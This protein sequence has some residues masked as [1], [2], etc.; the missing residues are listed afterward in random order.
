MKPASLNPF[1]IKQLLAAACITSIAYAAPVTKYSSGTDLSLPGSW[2]GGV[3]P[4]PTSGDVATWDSSSLGAGLLVN[5][6]VNWGSINITG[7]AENIGISG[8]G[9]ITTGNITLAGDKTL[10]ISNA[11]ALS[12]NSIYNISNVTGN[13]NTDATISGVISGASRSITKE[14][15]GTLTFTKVNT[16]TGGTFVNA[17]TLIQDLSVGG[18][19]NTLGAVTINAGAVYELL[20]GS[21]TGA[22]TT[23]LQNNTFSGEGTIRKTGTGYIGLAHS[24]SSLNTFNGIFDVQAGTIGVNNGTQGSGRATVQLNGAT[25]KL[26][27][28]TG[29]F[30]IDALT[31]VVGSQVYVSHTA[32]GTLSVGNNNGSGTFAGTIDNIGSALTF[33]KNGSGTQTLTGA[34]TYTGRTTINGGTLELNYES[35]IS[36]LSSSSPLT[37]GGGALSLSGGAT[38]T[39]TLNGLTT[40]ANTGS[41]ILLNANK[42]LTLGALTLAGANSALNFNTAAGG[43]NATTSTLGTSMVVLS[44]QTAG[45]VINKGFTVTDSTGFGLATVD[46]SNNVVRLTSTTLLPASGASSPNNYQIDNNAGGAAAA[47]SSS[48][49]ITASQSAGSITVD[50]TAASGGLTL[51]SG[52]VLSNNTWNFGG[53]GSNTYQIS[54]NAGGAGLKAVASN[55]TITFNNYNAG[56]VTISSPILAN[57]VN[58]VTLNGTGTTTLSGANTFTGAT[59]VNGGTLNLTGSLTSAVTVNTGATLAMSGTAI[60]NG[61]VTVNNGGV[62]N[63][64]TTTRSTDNG[65]NIGTINVASGGTLNISNTKTVAFGSQDTLLQSQVLTGAGTINQNGGGVVDWWSG[66][67]ISGF[68][69]TYNIQNGIFS[70][71]GNTAADMTTTATV[72]L[73]ASTG[74]LD[75]RTQSFGCDKLI[76]GGT[77]GSSYSGSYTLTVGTNNGSS[78]FDGIIRNGGIAGGSATIALTKSGTGTF[79]LTNA[80]TYT[81]ASTIKNGTLVLSGGDNRLSATTNLTLGDT[82]TTGK[83]VLGNTSAKSDLTVVGLATNGLGGSIVGGNAANSTLTVN[84]ASGTSTFTGILGGS[85]INENNLSLTKQG[86][87]TLLLTGANTFTGSTLVSTGKLYVNSPGSMGASSVTVSNNTTFGGSGTAGNV[88]VNNGGTLEGGYT[89]SGTLTAGNVTLG[90]SASDAVTLAGTLSTTAGYKPISVT[91]LTINGGDQKVMLNA[92]GLG[93]TNGT[94]YDLLV[95]TNAITAPNASS[96]LASLKSNARAYSAAVSGDGKKIQLLFDSNASIYWTGANSTAWNTSATNW[97]ITSNNNDT[98]FLANDIVL[99]NDG[100]TSS[101]VDIS[102]GNVTPIAATFNNSSSTTYTLQGSNG[103][104]AG[105]IT[106]NGSGTLN[107]NNTNTTTGA[108]TLNGGVVNM[109]QTGGLGSGTLTFDGSGATLNYTGATDSLS[110]TS[111]ALNAAATI[112]VTNAANTLNYAGAIGGTGGLTKTGGGTLTLTGANSYSGATTISAG[113]LVLNTVNLISTSGYTLNDANTGSSDTTLKIF[114]GF[115]SNR[116][117][118]NSVNLRDIAPIVVSNNG[119][120]TTTLDIDSS[121]GSFYNGLVTI[122]KAVVLKATGAGGVR[123]GFVTISGNGAGAGNDS[124]IYDATGSGNDNNWN[125]YENTGTYVMAP[126]SYIGNVR[127]TGGTTVIQN[128]SYGNA[129]YV[130]LMIPDTASVKVDSGSTINFAWGSEAIDGLNDGVGGGGT[131]KSDAADM[132]FTIGASNGSGSFSGNI[133][134]GSNVLS[135][136]KTGSGTQTLSGVNT[137][138]GATSVNGGTLQIGGAGKL[139]NGSYAGAISNSGIFNYASS[140]NQTLS[141]IIS[142]SG[143]LT[144]T[145]SGTLTLSGNNNYS[146]GTTITGGMLTAGS[147]TAFGT[148]SIALDGGTLNLSDLNITN[149][150]ALNGGTITGTSAFT[151]GYTSTGGT[152]TTDLGGTGGFTHTSGTTTLSGNNSYTGDTLVSGGTLLVNGSLGNTAVTVDPNGII[153]GTGSIAGSLTFGD[154]AVLNIL[155][156]N[157]ALS[158]TGNVSFANFGFDDIT[159]WDFANASEG[160]YTLLAGSNFDFTN[161][162]NF[163]ADDAFELGNGRSAYFQSGSLQVV[164]IP[165]PAAALIGSI[166]LLALLRRRRN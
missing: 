119:S 31:G 10:A 22:D 37:L 44:G 143:T 28:R 63:W 21:N 163:G 40:T 47:G 117:G 115:S 98:Q 41:R 84:L 93:L 106:K 99:F 71:Q 127:F 33:F 78:T 36:I 113:T 125:T 88:T 73:T 3:G 30:Q 141:G 165:E 20:T 91:N 4:A 126:N 55:D 59:T 48:L 114:G 81:G 7:A 27:V 39:Q 120:G 17:G 104:S 122:N 51:N 13:A 58:A 79:T 131:I 146:G 118:V 45:N 159:G 124:V 75:L 11:I 25:A 160:T 56:T 2:T 149:T 5:S 74:S 70:I 57:G 105:I 94:Y 162:E 139:G 121:S 54:G 89:G 111:M 80:N 8:T 138:T 64:N 156:I 144:M 152:V 23:L 161:V 9:Q 137:Y 66:C 82:A 83:L 90:A 43:A 150:I 77:V 53:V 95:S 145:G 97:K 108:V 46:A 110:A 109:S 142:G 158:I 116:N 107:I 68:S 38:A 148:G 34:N 154:G 49:A 32:G 16:Y 130:N 50:T 164:I 136:T 128:K 155:N 103:I 1:L 85:G 151:G 133:I 24:G 12:G 42:T 19:F 132:T 76:G 62:F 134:N 35:A 6:A 61:G 67:N 86:A 147:N 100:P 96:V 101:T 69:G 14:G 29:T 60:T 153:G 15:T 123:A 87:G 26:D 112:G 140:A 166:G 92:T 52:V 102:G 157:D 135:L 129:A 72:N 18:T 65:F